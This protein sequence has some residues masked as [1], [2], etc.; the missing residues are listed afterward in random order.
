M[1]LI[2]YL[3]AWFAILMRLRYLYR[4]GR[5]DIHVFTPYLVDALE[6]RSFAQPLPDDFDVWVRRA[7]N[8]R[9]LE[10]HFPA[11]TRLGTF[12]D[13][14]VLRLDAI[15]RGEIIRTPQYFD[16]IKPDLEERTGLDS[17]QENLL[18]LCGY[19][20]SQ[21][22]ED[23][24]ELHKSD[25]VTVQLL[26]AKEFKYCPAAKNVQ[27]AENQF[28]SATLELAKD[29]VLRAGTSL[30]EHERLLTIGK[31]LDEGSKLNYTGLVAAL[32]EVEA[33]R[34]LYAGPYSDYIET[35]PL[36]VPAVFTVSLLGRWDRF[37]ILREVVRLVTVPH[38]KGGDRVLR[39]LIQYYGLDAPQVMQMGMVEIMIEIAKI[40]NLG[41]PTP[42]RGR[43]SVHPD[44]VV[45]LARNIVKNIFAK[46]DW[47]QVLTDEAQRK[48]K[49]ARKG[50]LT[51]THQY[52][53]GGR[54]DPRLWLFP[55]RDGC[56]Y[57]RLFIVDGSGN[58]SAGSKRSLR[59]RMLK[60]IKQISLTTDQE[61]AV[62][63]RPRGL[64]LVAKAMAH[65]AC[66]HSPF[67]SDPVF[68]PWHRHHLKRSGYDPN[69][70]RQGGIVPLA[71]AVPSKAGRFKGTGL[72]SAHGPVRIAGTDFPQ[73]GLIT[74][75]I[76][77][78][79]MQHPRN[80]KALNAAR[81]FPLLPE[82]VLFRPHS[83]CKFR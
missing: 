7:Q 60:R 1:N 12:R 11:G 59:V 51:H 58:S 53:G 39:P 75:E 42:L 66:S 71:Q 69:R 15:L 40:A 77:A 30:A 5:T 10:Q 50:Y 49:P 55:E 47:D 4:H 41:R 38:R 26:L 83:G 28:K 17:E 29:T 22:V 14:P 25:P 2:T 18:D 56:F 46:D 3:N 36:S 8:Q 43:K 21:Y 67:T 6:G 74:P 82:S 19:N 45:G 44:H 27:A 78:A 64:I 48:L 73:E 34:P 13:A 65:M 16:S 57:R 33:G 24:R 9:A 54:F 31:K 63:A 72:P 35:L 23:L 52:G 70:A 32:E 80:Q 62:A 37:A 81:Q 20:V 61:S 68:M 79:L 76:I